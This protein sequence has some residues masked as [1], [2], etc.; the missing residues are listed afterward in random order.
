M[1]THLLETSI[2]IAILH[3]VEPAASTS[4][5]ALA[6]RR[7]AIST[8][9]LGELFFGAENGQS[10]VE[11][12]EAVERLLEELIVLDFD[13]R[14]ARQYGLTQAALRRVG[15]KIPAIDA[16]IAAIA[17]VHDLTVVSADKH[18]TYVEGLRVENWL[19]ET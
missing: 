2:A 5:L 14:A 9:T 18:F 3:G 1:T 10:P 7:V 8:C 15:R 12:A 4:R 6:D 11:E 16:Q 13:E 17:L 19:S